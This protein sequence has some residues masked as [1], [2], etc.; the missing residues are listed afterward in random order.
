M[1]NKK[2]IESTNHYEPFSNVLFEI[3]TAFE[4]KEINKY[5]A[6]LLIESQIK[7]CNERDEK[8]RLE[9]LQTWMDAQKE[10]NRL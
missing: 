5:K 7:Y 4:N 9:K 10:I 8:I 3:L 2:I 1:E 6:K